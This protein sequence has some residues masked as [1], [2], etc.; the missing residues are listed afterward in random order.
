MIPAVSSGV[1]A[2]TPEF[3]LDL[4]N[5]SRSTF[6]TMPTAKPHSNGGLANPLNWPRY[7]AVRNTD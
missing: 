5:T 2:V 1:D 4:Q 6:A 3:S 7:V